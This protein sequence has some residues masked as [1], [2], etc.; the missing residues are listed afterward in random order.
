[1]KRLTIGIALVTAAAV[2]APVLKADVKTKETTKVALEGILGVGMRIF[3][4]SAARDGITS[5]VAVKG[6]RKAQISDTTGQIIDLTE[7]K[8]YMLDMK[9][10]E[11]Q[12]Q[13]FAELRA[14]FEKAKAD[15]EKQK[16]EMKPE[17]KQQLEDASKQLEFEAKVDETGQKK[18]IAGYDTHE[19]VLTITAHEKGKTLEQSGGLVMTSNMWMGP[20]IAAMDERRD[21]ELR[22]AKALFGEAAIAGIQQQAAQLAAMYPSLSKMAERTDAERKKLSGTALSTVTTFEAVRSEEQVKAAQSQSSSSGGGGIGGA[23]TRRVM[24][25]RGQPQPRTKIMTSTTD[26]LSVA[27]TVAAEDVAIPAG[28]KEKK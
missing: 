3:G 14:A 16:A 1:M 7:Q 4:G 2:V 18:N 25:N 26:L 17:D 23:L 8:I 15:A 19:V 12:V 20:K 22:F 21:F 9:K 13:T 11:Y 27:T 6:N 24:G 28:F 10:K 5:T